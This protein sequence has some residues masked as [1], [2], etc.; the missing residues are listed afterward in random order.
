[1]KELNKLQPPLTAF[2][3]HY[4]TNKKDTRLV[5]LFQPNPLMHTQRNMRC[6]SDC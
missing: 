1:M 5:S 3:N 6:A 4:T 2:H